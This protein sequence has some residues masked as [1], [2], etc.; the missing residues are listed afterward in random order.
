MLVDLAKLVAILK[1]NNIV[2]KG[3]LHIGAHECEEKPFYNTMLHIPDDKIIWVDG[4]IRKVVEMSSKGLKVH[5]AVLDETE[6]EIEFNI[7][8]NSQASS[9]LCLNH[10]A[11]FYNNIHII[12]K[13]HCTTEKLSSFMERIAQDPKEFNFW[14]LDIQGSEFSVLLGSKELLTECDAIYT[15]V[16]QESV[17]KKCGLVDDLDILLTNYGFKRVYTVW[18]DM[19]WGDAL[20]VK[21]KISM[22]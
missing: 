13:Q 4:N 11:G 10:E 15:E 5:H 14:N 20:Y 3:V 17:Y 12:E 7:T 9:I 21:S 18:T 22:V 19:K 6:R 1:E 8:D 16:N 2:V